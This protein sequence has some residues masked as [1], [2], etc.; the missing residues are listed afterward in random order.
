MKIEGKIEKTG[1]DK[2]CSTKDHNQTSVYLEETTADINQVVVVYDIL[3]G[4]LS[5]I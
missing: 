4:F 5:V 2:L 3:E 1:S